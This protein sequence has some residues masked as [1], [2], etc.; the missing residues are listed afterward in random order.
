MRSIEWAL[1]MI[2]CIEAKQIFHECI[3]YTALIKNICAPK[4]QLNEIASRSTFQAVS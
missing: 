3:I 1:R 4:N 2:V